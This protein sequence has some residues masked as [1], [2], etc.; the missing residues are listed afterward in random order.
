[1][2]ALSY[3]M[4]LM[5]TVCSICTDYTASQDTQSFPCVWLLIQTCVVHFY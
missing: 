4:L 2:I 5:F 3:I 1:M